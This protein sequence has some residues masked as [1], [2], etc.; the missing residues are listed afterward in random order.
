MHKIRRKNKKRTK[1]KVNVFLKYFSKSQ[2]KTLSLILLFSSLSVCN[3]LF[4]SSTLEVDSCKAF[5][6]LVLL[7]F[8]VWSSISHFLA[9]VEL[10]NKFKKK[11]DWKLII[12][13]LNN[14]FRNL[15]AS[16]NLS[17][18]FSYLSCASV[19][20]CGNAIEHD[21]FSLFEY[22]GLSVNNW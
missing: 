5:V 10:K 9:F 7:L 1:Q 22:L 11:C 14:E 3:C 13:K 2:N 19:D 16:A 12:N 20:D 8:K 4:H 6:S 17:L 21:C 18:S 15:C